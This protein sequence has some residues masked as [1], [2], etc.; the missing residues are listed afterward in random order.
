MAYVLKIKDAVAV[1]PVCGVALVPTFLISIIMFW[2]LYIVAL[3]TTFIIA[4]I[5]F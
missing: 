4:V 3:G 5:V 1:C 2:L